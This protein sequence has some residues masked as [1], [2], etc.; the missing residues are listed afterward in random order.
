LTALAEVGGRPDAFGTSPEELHAF[1][2]DRLASWP[3]ALDALSTHDTKRSEDVRVRID[4]LSE[5][6]GLGRR[7][8]QRLEL[9]SRRF[10]RELEGGPAPDR[11]DEWLFYQTLLGA[12]PL[13]FA[14]AHDLEVEPLGALADRL[15]DYM[16]K[17]VREA[18]RRTSWSNPNLAY[19]EAVA[20]FVRGVL[21]EQRG[22]PFWTEFFRIAEPIARIGMLSGLSQVAIK[23]TAP[24]VPDL[25][26]GTELWDLSLVDPD[27]RRPVDWKR[28]AELLSDPLVN[29]AAGAESA[30]AMLKR[31]RDGRVKLFVTR[32]LLRLRRA[33]RE[34][35]L[36]GD[37]NA[38]ETTGER[39]DHIV[40]YVSGGALVAVPRLLAG[41]LAE[42]APFPL[43]RQIWGDSR[44]VLPRRRTSGTFR[45]AF[46]GRV[47]RVAVGDAPALDAADVFA[48]FPVAALVPEETE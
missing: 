16:L 2:A 6:T 28:R 46:T 21:G 20:A 23:L 42:R 26:A 39:A 40:A 12:W 7:T 41:L 37:Y 48:D 25:Y 38:L 13:E 35:F 30:T 8:L 34:M 17:A 43:G 45:D 18:K 31:W 44:L 29:G 22:S 14:E 11:T 3:Y 15:T 32:T 36:R 1:A 47:H 27:N 33:R 4:A 9:L 10:K 24:G 19:E 5:L